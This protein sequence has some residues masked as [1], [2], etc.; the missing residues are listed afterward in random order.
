M[1]PLQVLPKVIRPTLLQMRTLLAN[2]RFDLRIIT[3]YL[4]LS[5]RYDIDDS[6]FVHTTN[7][8][9]R[10]ISLQ[11]SVAIFTDDILNGNVTTSGTEFFAGLT[12]LS[13]SISDISGNL[14][15]LQGNMSALGGTTGTIGSTT[16]ASIT[17]LTGIRD[18]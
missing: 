8:K 15:F 7:V 18:T 16:Q 13:S 5:L 4:R 10:F 6:G 1:L 2:L 17:T 14:T 9:G 3:D 12:K 11:C